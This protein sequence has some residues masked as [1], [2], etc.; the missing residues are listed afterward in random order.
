MTKRKGA[1]KT[2][3]RLTILISAC[4]VLAGCMSS[5]VR[6]SILKL[7][8]RPQPHPNPVCASLSLF[9]PPSLFLSLSLY[10]KTYRSACVFV[11]W[12]LTFQICMTFW[13]AT[14]GRDFIVLCLFCVELFRHLKSPCW[15]L[16]CSI[17]IMA[18]ANHNKKMH[19]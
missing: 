2:P 7:R 18:T 16:P 11:S 4:V 17:F 12:K 6:L 14:A 10:L 9:L 1:F 8:D 19:D 13:G 15:L 5:L 3:A